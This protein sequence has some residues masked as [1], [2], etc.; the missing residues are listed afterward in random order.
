MATARKGCIPFFLE[1][2][3]FSVP[4]DVDPQNNITLEIVR[5][6]N[7]APQDMG[8]NIIAYNAEREMFKLNP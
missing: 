4:N 2:C 1:T 3:A 8:H 6:G 7:A 5:I